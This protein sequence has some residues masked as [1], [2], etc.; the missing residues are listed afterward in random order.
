MSTQ[1]L[2]VI[3]YVDCLNMLGVDPK[4]IKDENFTPSSTFDHLENNS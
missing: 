4:K 3:T 1:A 2:R